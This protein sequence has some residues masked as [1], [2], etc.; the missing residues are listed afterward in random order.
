MFAEHEWLA[1]FRGD[2]RK[3]EDSTR[4]PA[5][6]GQRATDDVTHIKAERVVQHGL[7]WLDKTTEE[8]RGAVVVEKTP[9][10]L[11]VGRV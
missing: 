5:E 4:A 2:S 11:A 9:N 3:Y 10:P 8:V 6:S 7:L 1:A